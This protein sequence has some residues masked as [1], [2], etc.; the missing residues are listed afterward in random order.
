MDQTNK[1]LIDIYGAFD[2][3]NY[4]DL[5]F[6][7]VIKNSLDERLDNLH[8]VYYGLIESDFT[9]FG[10]VR[11]EAIKN[12]FKKNGSRYG[13]EIVIVAGGEIIYSNWFFALQSLTKSKYIRKIYTK[14]RSLL[15]PSI[16]ET[17]SN[18]LLAP[19][20]KFPFLLDVARLPGH[21]RLI[22]NT[23]GGSS[24][25]TVESSLRM[26][27]LQQSS[28]ISVRDRNTFNNVRNSDSGL[29]PE[30]YPDSATL[31]SKYYPLDKLEGL[32][33]NETKSILTSLKDGYICFQISSYW[34]S[35]SSETVISQL[36]S[37]S[38]DTGLP[39]VLLPIGRAPYHSDQYALK[40]IQSKANFKTILP[41]ENSVFDIMA[42]IAHSRIFIGTSLHGA[43]TAMSFAI[44]FVPLSPDISKINSYIKTWFEIDI[45]IP[46]QFTEIY[47]TGRAMIDI[48]KKMLINCRNRLMQLS[49]ENFDKIAKCIQSDK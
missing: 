30:L 21:P 3:F 22:Y 15:G 39:V 12:R 6:P 24:V 40:I 32:I 45:P 38:S 7:L 9:R 41:D 1:I 33:G 10:G 23:V 31:M 8:Y 42:L 11:T 28:Y 48:N 29:S 5:L 17:A 46:A 13:K 43:I 47:K 34:F 2:R 49:E 19:A 4:G 37:L 25:S 36:S 20:M 27:Y 26:R 18:L 14:F 35:T 16:S 44:P